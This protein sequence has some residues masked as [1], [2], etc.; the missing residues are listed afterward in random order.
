MPMRTQAKADLV[1]SGIAL[2]H[3]R[4]VLSNVCAEVA[5]VFWRIEIGNGFCW[6]IERIDE[7][8]GHH[9]QRQTRRRLKWRTRRGGRVFSRFQY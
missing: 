1:E 8:R 4:E 2:K 9:G 7:Q 6:V 3:V 5:C